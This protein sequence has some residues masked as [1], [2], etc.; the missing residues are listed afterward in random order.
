[1]ELNFVL[2]G[3]CSKVSQVD[4]PQAEQ[5]QTQTSPL[6]AL[7]DKTKNQ[8]K[9]RD[10]NDGEEYR[11]HC[12]KWEMSEGSGPLSDVRGGKVCFAPVG[13]CFVHKGG[14][15]WKMSRQCRHPVLQT[16]SCMHR[17]T[18]YTLF[19]IWGNSW[20]PGTKSV[21]SHQT[22]FFLISTNQCAEHLHI[23]L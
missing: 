16:H 11:S 6:F 21:F 1:M 3:C 13:L 8:K 15:S 9:N 10:G 17:K 18:M 12:W 22:F 7:S 23:L 19:S 14:R 2:K 4:L 20:E 5:R